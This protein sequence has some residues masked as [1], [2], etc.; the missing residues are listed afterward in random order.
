MNLSTH[1]TLKEFTDSDTAL[2][3]GIDNTLP[4]ELT[5][6]AK[7]TADLMERIRAFL[8]DRAGNEVPIDITSGYRCLEL[9]R[10]I[11]SHDNSDHRKALACDFRAPT[12]GT[13]LE[14]CKALAPAVSVLQ[15]GQLIYE[16]TWVHVS[17]RVPDKLINR[18]ITVAGKDYVPG[19]VE[20]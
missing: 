14:I 10:S 17:V 15:I 9:N 16:H 7:A 3:L 5:D 6:N 20:A 2:R 18:I 4:V 8:S 1:F 13:P 12:F 19:I 11:G